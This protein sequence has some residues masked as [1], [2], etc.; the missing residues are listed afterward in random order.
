MKATGEKQRK[1]HAVGSSNT[2][3]KVVGTGA[4]GMLRRAVTEHVVQF[5]DGQKITIYAPAEETSTFME[6]VA[7]TSD[8]KIV[9]VGARKKIYRGIVGDLI[10][11]PGLRKPI[12][13]SHFQP[14]TDRPSD[15]IVAMATTLAGSKA[16]A[17]KWYRTFP[18]PAFG[19]VTAEFLVDHGRAKEVR[20]YLNAVVLGEFA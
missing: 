13:R 20:D 18:I 7:A 14:K 1:R 10:G 16:K 9:D 4:R 15:Q 2:T 8:L 6:E 5:K 17:E 3:S 19:G 11:I 12:S